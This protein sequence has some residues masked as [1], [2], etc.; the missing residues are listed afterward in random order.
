MTMDRAGFIGVGNMGRAMAMRLLDAGFPLVV[1][2]PNP[3]NVAPLRERGATI[4]ATPRDIADAAEIVFACLPSLKASQEVAL[5][6]NGI[7]KAKG[8]TIKVYV[9]MSTIGSTMIENIAEALRPAGI[10]FLDSPVSAPEGGAT[11]ARDGTLTA[12]VAGARESF[13]RAEPMLAAIASKVFFLG[14]KVGMAQVAKVIN[15]HLG[16][17]GKIAAF[18]G[19]AMG[20]MAGIDPVVLVD[21]INACSGR[22]A[23]T[24]EKFPQKIFPRKFDQN[25]SLAITIKDAQQFREEAK[26]VG[27]PL[28]FA[29]HDLELIEEAAANGYMN[30]DSYQIFEY[31]E[32]L[33]G[34]EGRRP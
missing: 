9:E 17:A 14:E 13:D 22:N 1:C 3:A 12:M 20:M 25:A 4:A 6:A 8:G 34:V 26:K 32:K 24:M 18:E 33:A 7:A 27:A 19:V 30:C 23:T 10:G 15:N 16:R 29:P 5:G 21:V 28:W 2:D 11:G 31:V